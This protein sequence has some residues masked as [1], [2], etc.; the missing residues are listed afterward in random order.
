MASHPV[1]REAL[2]VLN[3]TGMN[4]KNGGLLNNIRAKVNLLGILFMMTDNI[5]SITFD[6]VGVA[7]LS[8]V[9]NILICIQVSAMY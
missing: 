7:A 4:P 5:L 3:F 2:F 1:I 8:T 9:T 6:K